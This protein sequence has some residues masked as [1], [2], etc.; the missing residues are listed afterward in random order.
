MATIAQLLIKIGGD[1]SGLKKELAATQRQMKKA[2]G[3][4]S[5]ALS[6]KAG[7]TLGALAAA[8]MAVGTASVVTAGKMKQSAVAFDTLIG[9]T[10]E[11]K[12]FLKDLYQFA[13]ETPFEIEG[14]QET[15]KRLLA[16]KF[17]AKDIVPIM[18]T[19]GDAAGMLGSGQ[20]G[21]NRMT[22]AIAQMQS[23][24]KLQSQE[25]LQLAEAG[26]NAWQYLADS[27]GMSINDV[28]DKVSK[29]QVSSSQG[30]NAILMGMQKDFAGGMEK[31]AKE[32]PGLWATVMDNAKIVMQSA[33]DGLIESLGIKEKMQGLADYLSNFSEHV[34]NVGI[35]QALKD[36]VP[37]SLA[38]S[39]YAVSGAITAAAIPAFVGM[40]VAIWSAVAPLIPFIAI[41]AAVGVLGYTI[42]KGWEPLKTLFSGL[43]HN[44]VGSTKWAWAL[45]EK[46][47]FGALAS[48]F[49]GLDWIFKKVGVENPLGGFTDKLND[50]LERVTGNMSAARTEMDEGMQKIIDG[51]KGFGKALTKEFEKVGGTAKKLKKDFT[52]LTNVSVGGG[53][54][55]EELK[56]LQDKVRRTSDAIE[57]EWVQTTKTE[58]EQLDI[59]KSEQIAALDEVKGANE[60][61]QR[62]L[63]RVEAVYS[64][65][66]LKILEDEREKAKN[67]WSKDLG[68]A[69]D[70]GDLAKYAELL[71]SERALFEQDLVGRQAMI[72]EYYSWWSETHR[73]AMDYMSETLNGLYS[74]LENFFVD[75]INNAKSIGD[76][77]QG[78]RG[79]VLSMLGQMVA[80]WIASQLMMKIFGQSIQ[81]AMTATSAATAATMAAAWAPAAAAVSLASYGANAAPAMAGMGATY[82]LSSTLSSIPA[83]AEGGIATGPTLAMI[84]EGKYQEAVIPL[85]KRK[86]EKA[87]LA[88][89]KGER[90]SMQIILQPTFNTID[91]KSTQHW[92]DNGGGD[93]ITKYVRTAVKEFNTV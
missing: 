62:D 77:W 19:I 4:D 8:I 17:A 1:S 81:S 64:Q 32:I 25:M 37:P 36:M 61:H 43:W 71:N 24:G 51:S 30:I 29:G 63:E 7:K 21:I 75:I 59:W 48:V 79:A 33:G 58:L 56:K 89:D 49:N 66:R 35:N 50:N 86:L 57:R 53:L 84:G 68:E 23:K 60:N 6:S 34:K 28:M 40:A 74:G 91:G 22:L 45:I 15:A 20:E 3:A 5:L 39:I 83:L 38:I 27:M 70:D 80:K 44:I 9:D 93:A 85:N 73:T 72:D 87:G 90:R 76:A 78:L 41:G 46:V 31:Q 54:S 14:L 16:F 69:R 88:G 18:N 42:W 26:V 12:T 2:F 47:I 11:A 92:L 10:K 52:G 82:A 55:G 65:R 13:A 67:L